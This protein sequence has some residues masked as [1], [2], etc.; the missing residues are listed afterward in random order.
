[1]S[2]RPTLPAAS[3]W[4]EPF[5]A[6]LRSHG[7]RIVEI[8]CGPGLDAATVLNAGFE[9]T[10][11][12]REPRTINRAKE[13]APGAALML[14]DLSAPPFRDGSFDAALSSLALHYLP[15]QATI[16]AFAEIRRLLR[17]GSPFLFRV[18]ATDDVNH[19]A[20]EGIEIEPHFR[21]TRSVHGR[22][23]KRFFDEPDIRAAV[24]G[25]FAIEHL[26]H[27]TIHRYES[28]KQCWECLARAL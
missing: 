28:P 8:G 24:D 18:N 26:A 21:S 13:Q 6:A 1:M 3:D 20:L 4:L 12:D 10:G 16:A 14:A 2:N 15:W 11:L 9:V 23:L 22:D 27:R 7:P 25:L 17:P 5:F 19:G